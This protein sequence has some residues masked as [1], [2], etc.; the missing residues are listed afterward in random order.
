MKCPRCN[1]DD[2]DGPVCSCGY[3]P[4]SINTETQESDLSPSLRVGELSEYELRDCMIEVV[5]SIIARKDS[6]EVAEILQRFHL[7]TQFEVYDADA[8]WTNLEDEIRQLR[9]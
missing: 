5:G 4:G 1:E 6:Q 3:K 7:L 8:A 2:I 9:G